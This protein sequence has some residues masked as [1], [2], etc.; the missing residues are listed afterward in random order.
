MRYVILV[1]RLVRNVILVGLIG[2][3]SVGLS[4]II[5]NLATPVTSA[6]SA[7]LSDRSAYLADPSTLLSRGCIAARE[8]AQGLVDGFTGP[9]RG[10]SSP[11]GQPATDPQEYT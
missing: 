9:I 8:L 4:L 2:C 10:R 11:S 5:L 6:A 7:D 3:V 1:G